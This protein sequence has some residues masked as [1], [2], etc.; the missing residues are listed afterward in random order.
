MHE[1]TSA[2]YVHVRLGLLAVVWL[3]HSARPLPP[4]ESSDFVTS[5]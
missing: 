4:R 2:V 5:H 3:I 1:L